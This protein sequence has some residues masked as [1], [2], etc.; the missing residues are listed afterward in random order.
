MEKEAGS[1]SFAGMKK[2]QQIGAANKTVFLWI[3]IASVV[4]GVCAVTIQFMFRQ[5]MFNSKINHE[6]SIT[7]T[8]IKKN[9]ASYDSLKSDVDKL[10]AD[11]N[12]NILQ[13]GEESTP[14]QV[15]I[16]AMPTLEDRAAL[17]TSMQLEV[18]KPS[19][20]T[21]ESFGVSNNEPSVAIGATTT[22]D[23]ADLKERKTD[24]QLKIEDIPAFTVDFS[25][26]GTFDQVQQ[27]LRDME[28]SIRPINIVSLDIDGNS[29]KLTLTISALAY[30][31][32]TKTVDLKTIEVEP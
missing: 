21:I 2:R 10:T 18:L 16:D 13:K 8:D 3:I 12:L 11:S 32:P 5:M 20:V 31:I 6:L 22:P 29:N 28:R 4:V 15:V 30:Y 26:A 24:N 14:L 25:I 7:N 27:A 19:G 23:K 1:G 17:A 9:I